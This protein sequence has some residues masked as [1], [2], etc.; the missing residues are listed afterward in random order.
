MITKE[1]FISFIE[2]MQEQDDYFSELSKLGIELMFTTPQTLAMSLF[3]YIMKENF[4]YEGSELVNWW[5]YE[6]VEKKIYKSDGTEGEWFYKGETPSREV[7]ADLTNIED[8]YDY[9]VKEYSE[10]GQGTDKGKD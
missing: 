9:L 3:D 5:M 4:G 6:D 1:V 2:D 10:N 8:L 7:L